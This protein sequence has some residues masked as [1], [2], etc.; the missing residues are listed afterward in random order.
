MNK[1]IKAFIGILFFTAICSCS[2][3][4]CIAA[5]QPEGKSMK[6]LVTYVLE[7]EKVNVPFD[8]EVIYLR[9]GMAKMKTSVSVTEAVLQYKPDMVLNI[10]TVGTFRHKVGDV[11]VCRKFK[12]RDIAKVAISGL[13]SYIDMSND[14]LSGIMPK[15]AGEP[16]YECSTGDSFVTSP[17]EMD[18][19]VCDMEAFCIAYI[20]RKYHIPFASVKVVTDIVGSN[21]VKHWE[22][23][24]RDATAKL[25]EWFNKQ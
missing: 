15:L 9:T 1:I 16:I 21:S 19:D 8:G 10:G 14:D 12:D 18:S 23:A 22:D 6:L 11:L 20:C 25:Q 7:E 24:I 13:T 17:D 2:K 5:T 3:G 4:S